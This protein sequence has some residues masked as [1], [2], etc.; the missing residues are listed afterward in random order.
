MF[1]YALFFC[2]FNGFSLGLILI[3]M[4]L[5]VLTFFRSKYFYY[6]LIFMLALIVYLAFFYYGFFITEAQAGQP[7][8]IQKTATKVDSTLEQFIT[9]VKQTKNVEELKLLAASKK[10]KG[11]VEFA[12]DFS[13]DLA[14]YYNHLFV[15]AAHQQHLTETDL[16]IVTRNILGAESFPVFCT[17]QYKNHSLAAFV[18]EFKDNFSKNHPAVVEIRDG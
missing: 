11:S 17:D 16:L 4:F 14:T 12:P 1:F 8:S 5:V 3:D 9:E 7:L 6:F 10:N 13:I 18:K 15:A 2:F